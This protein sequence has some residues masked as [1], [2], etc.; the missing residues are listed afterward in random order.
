LGTDESWNRTFYATVSQEKK[1]FLLWSFSAERR[2]LHG[3]EN[4]A[5]YCSGRRIRG[6]ARTHR[7]EV[8]WADL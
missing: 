3:E 2:K 1:V 7:Q 4:N 5:R 8:D 6:R